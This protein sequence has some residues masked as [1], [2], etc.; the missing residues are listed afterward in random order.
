[1]AEVSAT[2]AGGT[3]TKTTKSTT[4]KVTAGSSASASL[5]LFR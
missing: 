5:D 2:N 4:G 1:V 3:T